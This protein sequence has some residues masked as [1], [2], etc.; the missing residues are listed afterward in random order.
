MIAK[1]EGHKVQNNKTRT[2]QRTLT[3]NGC[4]NKHWINNNRTTALGR[5]A[6]KATGGGLRW[7]YVFKCLTWGVSTYHKCE[8][9]RLWRDCAE[10]SL[11]AHTLWRMSIVQSKLD[12]SCTFKEFTYSETC[13]KRP[14][15]KSCFRA[16]SK[17]IFLISQPKHILWWLKRTE[18]LL[19]PIGA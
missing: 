4:K 13:V 12:Y 9:W 10:S 3:N 11:L 14:L 17:I 19:Q 5:T 1:L 16:V 15:P 6:A 8:Q 18:R 2:K 7:N